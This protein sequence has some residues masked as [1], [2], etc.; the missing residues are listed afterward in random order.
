MPDRLASLAG[1]LAGRSVLVT[2]ATGPIG[3]RLVEILAS[4]GAR[5]AV[6][7][8]Q[9]VTA[10]PL[11]PGRDVTLLQGDLVC[12]PT[13][14]GSCRGVDT[15]FHLASYSPGAGDTAPEDNPQHLAVTLDGTRNLL[16]EARRAGV[17]RF[18]FSSSSRAAAG[19]SSLYSQ[20]KQ[21][22]EHLVLEAG[23]GAMR[24]SILR[25]API[26]G[27]ADR[28]NV[29]LMARAV[30]SG[31]FPPIGDFGDRRSLLHVDDAIQAMLLVVG[32]PRAAGKT[33]L[34]TDLEE[35]S[36]HDIYRLIRQALGK[37]MPHW[38]MPLWLLRLLAR[39]GDLLENILGRPA[40]L[41][42][43]KLDKLTTSAVFN[44]CDIQ[45]ELGYQPQ[46]TLETALPGIIAAQQQDSTG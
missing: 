37:P 45:R 20:A 14:D 23:E 6:L 46:H 40:P 4:G 44:A 28:G 10:S 21:Q 12:A 31:R 36:S 17:K 3:Q 1:Q 18:V 43:G 5:V 9:A 22:A 29:A 32:N 24:V 7:S 35:Y 19:A 2:G 33:Y 11:W 16:D 42:T 25:F 8:R 34:V 38:T 27:F 26:Y 13:L 41:S 15:V 39:F 30:S